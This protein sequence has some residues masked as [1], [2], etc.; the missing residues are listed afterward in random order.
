M[1]KRVVC[2]YCG[3][4]ILKT[5][6]IVIGVL[7]VT[8]KCPNHNCRHQPKLLEWPADVDIKADDKVVAE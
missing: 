7:R 2:K 6:E 8:S 1:T 3:A 4:L 5:T